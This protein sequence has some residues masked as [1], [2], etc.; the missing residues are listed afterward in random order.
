MCF[1]IVSV[2]TSQPLFLWLSG[3][4]SA[5]VNTEFRSRTPCEAHPF[6]LPL[7]G[8]SI[9]KSSLI[10][11][12]IFF[13]EGGI[14]ELAETEKHKPSAWL[15]WWY[16]SCPINTTLIESYGVNLNELKINFSGGKQRFDW[17]ESST[18]FSKFLKYFFF[19]SGWII[20]FH[21]LWNCIAV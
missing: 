12:N 18:N 11:L 9:F 1:I 4:F 21:L 14:E 10:S 15:I 19:I 16:G 2:K 20:F 5:T 13:K 3:L 6:R 7:K 8:I 17:Y